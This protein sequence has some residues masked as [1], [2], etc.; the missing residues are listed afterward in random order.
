M[1]K[2]ILNIVAAGMVALWTMPA[3]C[4]Y[5]QYRDA[6]GVLRFTDDIASVPPDQRPG[7]TTHRSVVSRPAQGDSGSSAGS[8]AS[9]SPAPSRQGTPPS[10]KTWEGKTASQM[11]EFDRRQAE[12]DR[13]FAELQ[14]ERTRLEAKAPSPKASF[15]EKAV[16]NRKVAALNAKIDRYEEELA[17]YTQQ[18]KAYN[19]QI[20][21]K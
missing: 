3:W 8:K 6:N 20:K 19:A 12:L 21:K 7:V 18:V 5:Y 16:Y 2:W 1:G 13:T 15:E 4:E 9:A 17:A 11:A 14:N 10:A